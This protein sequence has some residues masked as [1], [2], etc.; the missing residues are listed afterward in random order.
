[1]APTLRNGMPIDPTTAAYLAKVLPLLQISDDKDQLPSV[2]YHYT[3]ANGLLG[4]LQSRK[5]W[6][7]DVMYLND[8][9]E[10]HYGHGLGL[11]FI[12]QFREDSMVYRSLRRGLG[13]LSSMINEA[14]VNDYIVSFCA[15]PDLLSQWRAY[16][17]N[18]TGFAIGFDRS[19]LDSV[20]A[21]MDYH[22]MIA[23][24]FPIVYGEALQ[25]KLFTEFATAARSYCGEPTVG[26]LEWEDLRPWINLVLK[27]K[28]PLFREE[29]EWRLSVLRLL[30]G[31]APSFRV[32]QGNIIPYWCIPLH[33]DSVVSVH[34]GPTA[35]PELSTRVVRDLLKYSGHAVAKAIEV[36]AVPLRA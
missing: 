31:A 20:I 34:V 13:Y 9:K 29:Q 4:I 6:A 17:R 30:P 25:Q 19:V 24:L 32:R 23:S 15:K 35:N 1:M 12:Q 2:L 16:G 11:A 26:V 33:V 21:P 18:G 28:H 8:S 10:I 3:D 22:N 5:L 14:N 7:S 27:C 36:S